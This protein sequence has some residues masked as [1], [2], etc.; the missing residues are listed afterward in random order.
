MTVSKPSFV[1]KLRFVC[2]LV[3]AE[4]GVD[5]YLAGTYEKVLHRGIFPYGSSFNL[6]ILQEDNLCLADK[7]SET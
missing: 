1:S 4:E 7:D 3:C 5:W 2:G 6:R